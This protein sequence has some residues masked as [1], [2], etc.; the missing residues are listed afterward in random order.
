MV[1]HNELPDPYSKGFQ[2][3]DF[4]YDNPTVP[5]IPHPGQGRV[6]TLTPGL[7]VEGTE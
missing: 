3:L 2:Q 5:T 6:E 7:D 4:D 1:A